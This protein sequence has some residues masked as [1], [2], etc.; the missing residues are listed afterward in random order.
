MRRKIVLGNYWYEQTISK[1][2]SLKY[3]IPILSLNL[4]VRNSDRT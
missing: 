1:L 2:S 3:F 4:G